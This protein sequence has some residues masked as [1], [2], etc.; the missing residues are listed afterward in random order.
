MDFIVI[1]LLIIFNGFFA[2][3]EIAIVSS[4]KSKLKN[5]AMTGGNKERTAFN[6]AEN[7]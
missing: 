4:R 3:A 2:M 6:L 1:F 7:P 5:M